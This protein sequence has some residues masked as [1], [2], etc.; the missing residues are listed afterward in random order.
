MIENDRMSTPMIRDGDTF[1]VRLQVPSSA[2]IDYAF[3]ITKSRSGAAVE[4]QDSNGDEDYQTMAVPG[5]V[6]GI[7]T[8]LTPEQTLSVIRR[9]DVGLYMLGGILAIGLIRVT[10]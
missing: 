10:L 7:R 3:L 1:V 4:W 9:L 5:G 8:A 6:I 2:T